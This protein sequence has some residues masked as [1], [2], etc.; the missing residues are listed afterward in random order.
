M[1][2][3]KPTLSAWRKEERGMERGRQEWK[4]RRT[5]EGEGETMISEF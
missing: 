2:S 3:R 4:E 1:T 5:G